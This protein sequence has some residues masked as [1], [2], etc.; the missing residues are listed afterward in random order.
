MNPICSIKDSDSNNDSDS[1][2]IEP[3]NTNS[4]VEDNNHQGHIYTSL[5]STSPSFACGS[6]MGKEHQTNKNSLGATCSKQKDKTLASHPSPQFQAQN[7]P[8][9]KTG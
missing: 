3:V 7:K 2:S 6:M 4:E 9:Y 8:C 1:D 5:T